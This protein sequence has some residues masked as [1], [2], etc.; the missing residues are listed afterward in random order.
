MN[1]CPDLKSQCGNIFGD[2]NGAAGVDILGVAG[3]MNL[4]E[5]FCDV[6]GC[7]S[8]DGHPTIGLGGN[9]FDWTKI[10]LQ[11]DTKYQFSAS[12]LG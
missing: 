2:P 9:E 8:W 1:D 7:N 6:F 5:N 11:T 10:P 12:T 3:G 4:G